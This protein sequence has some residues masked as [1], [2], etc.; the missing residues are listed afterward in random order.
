VTGVV[1][2]L[3]GDGGYATIV[4]LSDG[5]TSMYTSGGGGMI[6]LGAAPI[7]VAAARDLFMAVQT[8]L[9][10]FATADDGALPPPD[11]VRFHVIGPNGRT[12]VDVSDDVFWSE[13]PHDLSDVTNALHALI[14]TIQDVGE[15]APDD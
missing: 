10:A 15:P 4:A 11:A 9:T 6:G 3:P 14:G 13:R 12:R 5:T 7:V 2:D 1:V 8:H